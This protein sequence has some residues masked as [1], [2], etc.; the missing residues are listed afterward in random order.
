A[1]ASTTTTAG[2]IRQHGRT[3]GWGRARLEARVIASPFDEPDTGRSAG[4]CSGSRRTRP[5][6]AT[7]SRRAESGP[8]RAVPNYRPARGRVLPPHAVAA[9]L[10]F[11]GRT[12]PSLGYAISPS[13]KAS[14][15]RDCQLLNWL[16]FSSTTTRR[17]HRCSMFS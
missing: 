13:C 12:A 1:R 3:S 14:T 16:A 7:E 4:Y 11:A 8:R 2:T 5:R 6:L 17:H 10:L 9:V 15:G